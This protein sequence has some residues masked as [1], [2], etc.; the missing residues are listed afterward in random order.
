MNW[1]PG[2]SARCI[3]FSS[4]VMLSATAHALEPCGTLPDEIFDNGFGVGPSISVDNETLLATPTDV[5]TL[6]DEHSS[7]LPPT[8]VGGPFLFFEAAKYNNVL[9]AVVM[10]TDSNFQTLTLASGYATP[11]LNSPKPFGQCASVGDPAGLDSEFD[12]NY[13]APGSVLQDPTLPDGNL[14]MIYE[15]ENHCRVDP[16]DGTVYNVQPYYATAGFARSSDNGVTWPAPGLT[17]GP[18]RYPILG[19]PSDKP[20]YDPDSITAV[21]DAIPSGY[22]KG[23]CLYVVYA[24][25]P[26]PTETNRAIGIQIA[27]AQLGSDPLAFQKYLVTSGTGSFSSAGMGGAGTNVIPFTPIGGTQTTPTCTGTQFQPGLSFNQFLGRYLMTMVCEVSSTA[28]QLGWF[29]STATSL[30]AEDWTPP[31]L[32]ANSQFTTTTPCDGQPPTSPSTSFNGWYPSFYSPNLAMGR[33]GK[34]GLAFYL[35]GCNLDPDRMFKSR[36]FTV[37][38]DPG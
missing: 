24:N 1:M 33:T 2:N 13:A 28:G 8:T 31:Q 9:G 35:D 34:T 38:A 20:A 36:T 37:T 27:R 10:Q 6:P 17:P 30:D 19:G 4:I 16:S 29:F 7:Y 23:S 18:F 3:G 15:G 22:I 26:A 21:G 12:E 32:I 14:M 11:V 25:H 5:G